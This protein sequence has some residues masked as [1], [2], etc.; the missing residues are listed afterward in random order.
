MN[1]VVTRC[2]APIGRRASAA[3]LTAGCT[4]RVF[5]ISRHCPPNS[6]A[7]G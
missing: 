5:D 1:T 2:A 4:F 3:L 6:K 7:E